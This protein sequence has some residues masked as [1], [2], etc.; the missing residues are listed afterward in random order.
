MPSPESILAIGSHIGLRSWR[1]G[2]RTDFFPAAAHADVEIALFDEGSMRYRVG[3][4]EV[5]ADGLSLAV[6][7]RG[8]EHRNA[9]DS[10]LRGT[11]LSISDA[12]IAEITDA[13]A[14]RGRALAFG[15]VKS[16]RA[17]TLARLLVDEARH[18]G[19]GRILAGEAIA[20][21][22][23]VELVRTSSAPTIS[24]ARDPRIR[25]ALD[26]MQTSYARDLSVDDLAK[27]AG[28]SR[29]HFSRLFRDQVGEAPY[30]HLLR[31]RV[32]RA[33]ELLRGGRHSVTEAA[34]AVGFNDLSRFSR[35]FRAEFGVN[36]GV[37]RK[38][39]SA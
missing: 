6:V 38:A 33:A 1:Y 3:S 26:A 24:G 7:P 15:L 36:P 16:A 27:T 4:R 13:M 29:F 20:E 17:L 11:A 39:R 8:V 22:L 18:E 21:A 37:A 35:A 31:L 14:A 12:M 25:I 19:E 30:K 9:F 28:M 34:F 2:S 23:V 5:T 32:A 10:S